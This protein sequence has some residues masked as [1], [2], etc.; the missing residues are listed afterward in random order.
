MKNH[1]INY[2]KAHKSPDVE[3]FF[4]ISEMIF[5]IFCLYIDTWYVVEN[6]RNLKKM[7]YISSKI[8]LLIDEDVDLKSKKKIH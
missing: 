7:N 6:C 1:S 8:R 4:R 5:I 3:C 2:L